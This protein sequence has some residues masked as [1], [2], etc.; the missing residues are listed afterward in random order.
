MISFAEFGYKNQSAFHKATSVP[1]S[2]FE[3]IIASPRGWQIAKQ[4]LL[5]RECP[6]DIRDKFRVD[7]AWYKR[8]TALY[9]KN[10]PRGYDKFGL[11][12]KDPRVKGIVVRRYSSKLY[13]LAYALLNERRFVEKI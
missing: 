8:L 3:A 9:A 4:A 10:A 6:V 5:H 1:R 13:D 12:D 2:V 7:G 11:L